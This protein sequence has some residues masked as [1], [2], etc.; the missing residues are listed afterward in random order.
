[1]AGQRPSS[2]KDVK[3]VPSR[4]GTQ[5]DAAPNGQTLSAAYGRGGS[6][7][8]PRDQGRL[9]MTGYNRAAGDIGST[10]SA[11]DPVTHLE[12]RIRSLSVAALS[13]GASH[14]SIECREAP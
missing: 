12:R 6:G 10:N 3:C 9:G 1:M 4:G 7:D 11:F 8:N 2:W 13:H 5:A 14:K